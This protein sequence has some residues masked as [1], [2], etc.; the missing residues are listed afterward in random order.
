MTESFV[1]KKSA[2]A[3]CLYSN[4][5]VTNY[6]VAIIERMI[7]INPSSRSARN[8]ASR[9]KPVLSSSREEFLH[10]LL[11]L[12]FRIFQKICLLASTHNA[13]Y[14]GNRI[15]FCPIIN[16]LTYANADLEWQLRARELRNGQSEE[17]QCQASAIVAK[18]FAMVVPQFRRYR[19]RRDGEHQE[20]N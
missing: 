15:L 12:Y 8:G 13:T 5:R 1:G 9:A 6:R 7:R 4:F 2:P 17:S 16:H 19:V 14:T 10:R 18:S 3:L 11:N 20:R